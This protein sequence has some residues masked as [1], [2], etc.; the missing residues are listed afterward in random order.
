VIN[1]PKEFGRVA[2]LMGG[3][4]AEREV[5]LNS[6]AAVFQALQ[7]KNVDVIAIDITGNPIDAL[8]GQKIDRVFNIVHGR[9]GEDGVLQA[10]LE[11]MGIPYTGSGVMASAV[12][13]DKLRTK[14][15]WLGY[16]LPTPLWHLLKNINDVD[17]C[18]EQLGFPVIVKPAKE[19]SSIGMSKASN[20][21]ELVLAFNNA[22]QFNCDVYAESWVIGE[23]YTVA[24]L[25]GKALPA[26]RLET[27]NAFYDYEAKYKA[28]TTQYH[29]P[30]GLSTE[31]ENQLQQLAVQAGEVIGIR[32]W[33][34]VDVF[35]DNK[36]Q[37][38]LIEINTVPGMTDHSLV[39][40]AAKQAG[41]EFDD[42]VWRILETSCRT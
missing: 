13:M 42:L 10:V 28:S 34:R 18:V 11:V 29:C 15:C 40:M 21:N 4:A 24:L 8:A 41:I 31:Q 39:P 5:S 3:T 20:R 36:D 37:A 32:G 35:I 26:I 1:N 16:G 19:G 6:G 2:V 38:Q 23:E 12:S 22:A 14:L 17:V 7:R 30:C 27:P 25:D 33:S 9:G